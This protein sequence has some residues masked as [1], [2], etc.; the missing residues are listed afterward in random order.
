MVIIIF[1]HFVVGRKSSF[2]LASI[3]PRHL[4]YLILT[5][6]LYYFSYILLVFWVIGQ[7]LVLLMMIVIT[8]KIVMSVLM[9]FGIS[10]KIILIISISFS[11]LPYWY[12]C[13]PVCT[14]MTLITIIMP[15]CGCMWTMG[16]C[17]NDDD[18]KQNSPHSSYLRRSRIFY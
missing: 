1:T 12:S 13:C 4:L 18:T 14:E 11:S 5:S 7:T 3:H 8:W 16:N 9:W 10:N 6:G 17:V 2:H 15:C